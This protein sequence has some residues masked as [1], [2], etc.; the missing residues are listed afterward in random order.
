MSL[1]TILLMVLGV[2]VVVLLIW[3]FSTGWSGFWERISPFGSKSNIDSIRSGCNLACA[4][5]NQYQFCE[6]VRIVKYGKEIK[7]WNG[8]NLD[9]V[10]QS[11][12]TCYNMTN[13]TNYPGVNIPS[14]SSVNCG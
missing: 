14:C 1:T 9:N 2:V 4:S 6:E 5:S 11:P 7:A 3:G 12:G 10:T 8:T 13:P